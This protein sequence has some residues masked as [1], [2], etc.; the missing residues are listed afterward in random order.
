MN[1]QT[2]LR[3]HYVIYKTLV[4]PQ[5]AFITG[6]GLAAGNL[7]FGRLGGMW[8]DWCLSEIHE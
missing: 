7:V 6:G 1:R 5:R 8:I 3:N 2:F 4:L